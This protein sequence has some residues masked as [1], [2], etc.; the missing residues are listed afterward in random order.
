MRFFSYLFHDRKDNVR[1]FL[2]FACFF[3]FYLSMN[4]PF[5]TYMNQNIAVLAPISPFYGVPFT[6]NLFNFDP[7]LYYSSNN[8]TVI[9][10]FINLISFPLAYLSEFFKENFFFAVVQSIMNALGVVMVYYYLRKGWNSL[11]TPLLFAVFFGTASYQIF[12][13]MIPDS[14]PYAQ[15]VIL[16]SVLYTQYSRAE[17]KLAVWPNASF[18]L[19]NFGVTSTNIIPFMSVLAVN[20]FHKEKNG[21]FM[22]LVRIALVFLLLI[23]SFTILQHV[24]FG[25]SWFSTWY[26]AIHTGGF[27]YTAPF[28]FFEHWKALYMLVISPVLTPDITL[29]DPKPGMVAFAT[30]LTL[31]YPWYVHV[32]GLTLITLGILGFIKGIRTQEA[33]SLAAYIGFAFVLHIVIGFGLATF[34]Y[35]LYLYAGHYFFAFFL[36]AARFIMHLRH[37][38]VKKA[39]LGLILLFVIVTLGNNVVKHDEALHVIERSYAQMNKASE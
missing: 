6:L 33:W 13:A 11:Y 7:T 9:H 28:S 15:F 3:V 34:T 23:I 26:K 22:K 31:P 36:L 21:V 19:V 18:A 17:K 37:V 8:P 14:Y 5:L 30:N 4:V 20:L 10:P 2:L 29:I 12:T 27:I 16:F 32:I 35:D 25:Q 39:L 1:A 38:K 24:M